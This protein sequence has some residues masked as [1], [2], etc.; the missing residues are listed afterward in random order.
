M[1]PSSSNNCGTPGPTRNSALKEIGLCSVPFGALGKVC[2][3]KVLVMMTEQ[4]AGTSAG[5]D[6]KVR[7]GSATRRGS[8]KE[9]SGYRVVQQAPPV[10][11]R[12][13]RVSAGVSKTN[14]NK[15][16]RKLEFLEVEVAFYLGRPPC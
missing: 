8:F 16:K 1:F 12:L 13:S 7:G 10:P 14:V 6:A 5:P 15:R 4:Q 2:I 11:V 3:Q 9:A